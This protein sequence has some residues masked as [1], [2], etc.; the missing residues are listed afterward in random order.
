MLNL[1]RAANG[2]Y[3][4][5]QLFWEQSIELSEAERSIEPVF[6]LYKDKP[7]LINLGKKYVEAEDPTGYKIATE[8]LG[9]Y[10]LWTTL[11]R[12]TWFQTVTLPEHPWT[13]PT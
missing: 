4:T 5:K 13:F 6:T 7:N 1:P 12:C 3:Y 9:D 10:K 8:L 2:K 11:M